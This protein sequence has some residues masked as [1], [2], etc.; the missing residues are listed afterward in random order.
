ME[1]GRRNGT[2]TSARGQ[3]EKCA[4]NGKR[5]LIDGSNGARSLAP[6]LEIVVTAAEQA[7]AWAPR[8]AEAGGGCGSE[9]EFRT[10]SLRAR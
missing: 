5:G 6:Y 2:L 9:A 1:G 4:K 8:T 3:T 7:S 10:K